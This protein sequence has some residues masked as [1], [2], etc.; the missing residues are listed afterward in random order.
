[1]E[2]AR[3]LLE[4]LFFNPKRYDLAKVGRHKV[5]KKLKEEFDALEPDPRADRPRAAR[6]T[7]T[8]R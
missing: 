2:S 6:P 1:M 5:N 4:N 8:S 7:A 3:G